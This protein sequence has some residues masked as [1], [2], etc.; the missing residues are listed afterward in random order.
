MPQVLDIE[1]VEARIAVDPA[2]DGFAAL[3][4]HYRRQGRHADALRVVQAGLA[5]RPEEVAGRLV[6]GLL[7]WDQAGPAAARQECERAAAAIVGAMP[8]PTAFDHRLPIGEDELDAALAEAVP[9]LD[10]RPP[11]V[12]DASPPPER[13]DERSEGFAIDEAPMFATE[14]MAR[15]FDAQGDRRSADAIRRRLDRAVGA[16][17]ATDDG[18]TAARAAETEAS[19]RVVDTLETWLRNLQGGRA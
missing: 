16:T 14:T 2:A 4:E 10:E 15:L 7:L 13:P 17:P 1:Q 12:L 11:P 8:E 18:D 3:A 5:L 6:L 19:R 9:I